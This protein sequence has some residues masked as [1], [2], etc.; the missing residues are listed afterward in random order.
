MEQSTLQR[1][2]NGQSFLIGVATLLLLVG[3]S[4]AHSEEPS[5]DWKI[6]ST[7]GLCQAQQLNGDDYGVRIVRTPASEDTSVVLFDTKSWGNRPSIDLD[8]ASI[9]VGE[10]V[11]YSSARVGFARSP[12]TRF[13]SVHFT[14][15]D[16]L[17][18]FAAASA[19][20]VSHSK[21]GTMSVTYQSPAVAVEGLQKCEDSKMAAWGINP[22]A[23]HAL[24]S[25][26]HPLGDYRD[27]I[28]PGSNKLSRSIAGEATVRLTIATDGRVKDC[29]G[30]DPS[31]AAEL[32]L[33]ACNG[34][35]KNGR[36]TPA[37]DAQGNPVESPYVVVAEFSLTPS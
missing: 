14:D 11:A 36:Y 34:L 25:R 28:R 5:P 4:P 6:R 33:A 31:V 16:L 2:C 8:A 30:I 24:R 32:N 17:R 9:R 19:V 13:A 1:S 23:W 3:A 20:S 12:S 29:E 21:L 37:Y 27:W 35:I 10:D 7:F 18:H 15:P 22:N 26:P